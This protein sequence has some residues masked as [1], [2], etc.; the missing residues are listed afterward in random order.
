MTET[1]TSTILVS[2]SYDIEENDLS[3]TVTSTILV[4]N[5]YDIEGSIVLR[6]LHIYSMILWIFRPNNLYITYQLVVYY[7]VRLKLI[8][9]SGVFLVLGH[10]NM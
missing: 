1:V 8:G 3:E 9:W 10:L 4:S 5:S 7:K 6:H 2:N